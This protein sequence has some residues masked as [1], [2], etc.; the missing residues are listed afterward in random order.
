MNRV[1]DEI[2][3]NHVLV[4]DENGVNLGTLATLEA[5]KVAHSRGMD[6]VE[7]G[8]GVC[9]IADF[10][11]LLYAQKKAHKSKAAPA[12]K[13]FRFGLNIAE[14]DLMIKM[15]HINELLA[16]NHPIRVVVQFRGRENAKPEQGLALIEIIKSLLVS[17]QVEVAGKEGNKIIMSVRKA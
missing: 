3:E 16:K 7:V 4:I 14:H 2:E 8:R 9:K 15:R 10:R 5:M 17:A 11:K 13:E 1:N 12:L 6:L